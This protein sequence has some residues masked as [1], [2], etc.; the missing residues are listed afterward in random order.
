MRFL[1]EEKTFAAPKAWD[2]ALPFYGPHPTLPAPGPG[3]SSSRAQH[4]PLSWPPPS[5]SFPIAR[6]PQELHSDEEP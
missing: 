6:Q 5:A 4:W 1:T 2:L 3:P